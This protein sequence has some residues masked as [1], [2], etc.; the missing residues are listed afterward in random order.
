M[1][2]NQIPTFKRDE[3]GRIYTNPEKQFVRPFEMPI[4]RPNEM[5][6]LAA[7]AR[8]G[9]FPFTTR[10][11]GPFEVAYIKATVWGEEIIS[12]A[13]ETDTSGIRVLFEA[14]GKR[15]Q[16][17]AQPIPLSCL[18]GD[19]GAPYVLP[20]TI[21][22]PN[23][24]SLDVTI[25]NDTA[26]TRNIEIVLGGIK[27]YPNAA[28]EKTRRELYGY[29]SLRTRTYT[30]WATTD[31][32]VILTPAQVGVGNGLATIPDDA[33]FECFKLTSESTGP[34]RTRIVE[35]SSDRAITGNKIYCG[36]LFGAKRAISMASG[37]LSSG[38]IFPYRMATSLLV[39]RST[40]LQF[41]VDDMSGADN[42]VQMVLGGRKISY[43][44]QA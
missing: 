42:T 20:E 32:P 3:N 18:A 10:W 14:P 23:P 21:F 35:A 7:G 39:R 25:F 41:D 15:V 38:G 5:V 9:P 34:Y 11:D 8:G 33:D 40:Q 44:S 28:P 13:P 17:S 31:R 36:N 29:A 24:Q 43:G 26:F 16:L 30:Y 37:N 2:W 27:F 12:A 4:D 19:A 6:T 22:L 1:S